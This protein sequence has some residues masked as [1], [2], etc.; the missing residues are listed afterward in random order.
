MNMNMNGN[1]PPPRGSMG[2]PSRPVDKAT[3]I[4]N[5]Q[6]TLT[7]TGV[8]IDEEERNLTAYGQ[9][10]E[11]HPIPQ[12]DWEA[13]RHS[14][15]AMW[16][17]FLAGDPLERRLFQ[18]AYDEGIKSPKE[19][20]FYATKGPDRPPQR[21]RVDG[22]DGA[23]KVIDQG[24][25]I[26]HST[27]GDILM[28]IM[29]LISLAAKE[30]ATGFLDSSAR[31]ARER[32]LHSTGQVPKEWTNVAVQTPT[33]AETAGSRPTP[34]LKRTHSQ[35][36]EEEDEVSRRHPAADLFKKIAQTERAAEEVRLAKRARRNGTSRTG[37][38]STPAATELSL[39]LA[40]ESEKK[41]TKKDQKLMTSKI[42]EAQQHKSANE[43]A[44][45]AVGSLGGSSFLGGKK[46]KQYAWMTGGANTPSSA[47][48]PGPAPKAA[49]PTAAVAA[50]SNVTPHGAR[51]TSGTG[52]EAKGVGQWDED[53]DPGIQ[54]RDVLL[55]LESDGKAPKSLL[56]GYNVPEDRS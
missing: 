16:N 1:M 52:A 14:Q 6:D 22:F 42:T 11:S 25:T 46:K 5:L 39:A 13:A 54:A 51:H 8:N 37:S 36:N 49:T 23:H 26:L 2:P 31:L 41:I 3:D 24:E 21:T 28:Q 30:R 18:R 27:S 12:A 34:S 56:R 10:Q 15:H 32:R 17:L 47:P 43:T 53:R 40:A 44:R 50:P 45:L 35:A 55:V 9:S 7:G 4:R 20:L 38:I 19:G 48:S 33:P 29:Q